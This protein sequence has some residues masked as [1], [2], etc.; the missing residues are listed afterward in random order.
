MEDKSRNCNF[1]FLFLTRKV[2]GLL[3]QA[4]LA[5]E[6]ACLLDLVGLGSGG[7]GVG[8]PTDFLGQAKFS[9]GYMA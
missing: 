7:G 2:S 6:A 5:L 8:F 9:S 1:A 4:S 3:F